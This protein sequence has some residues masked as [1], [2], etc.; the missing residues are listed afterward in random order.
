M[1]ALVVLLALVASPAPLP[2]ALEAT[3][4]DLQVQQ[5]QGAAQEDAR[6]PLAAVILEP[7]WNLVGWM[8]AD[9]AADATAASIVGEFQAL[10]AYDSLV[11]QFQFF[12]G[13]TS[14]TFLNTLDALPFGAGVW[15]FVQEE[16]LWIQPA[17]WWER[18]V[19]LQPGFNLA[20][21][22]G[23]SNT[24]IDEALAG[25]GSSLIAAFTYDAPAQTFL[26]FGPD[27][28]AFLNSAEFLNYGDGV[29]LEV[30]E[31]VTWEQP[32]LQR[33]GTQDVTFLRR[34][35]R[36]DETGAEVDI[37]DDVLAVAQADPGPPIP[38]R[39]GLVIQEAR[40]M[41][42]SAVADNGAVLPSIGMTF[43]VEPPPASRPCS[44]WRSASQVSPESSAQGAARTSHRHHRSTRPR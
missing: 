43:G 29:W 32:A 12:G 16:S 1:L 18:S 6:F 39:F 5:V 11:Q 17:P 42:G 34:I 37:T 24:P 10:Y 31:A 13:P 14:P 22:T 9:A 25:L 23:P 28:L 8:G 4:A 40:S 2:A 7:G 27:R 41:R 33:I 3:P 38:L 15:I 26:S 21:W 30:S 44:A 20:L 36:L 19:D 35:A